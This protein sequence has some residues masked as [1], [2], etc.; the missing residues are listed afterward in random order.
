MSDHGA[1]GYH[2]IIHLD[3]WLFKEGYLKYQHQKRNIS[4]EVFKKVYVQTR[5]YFPRFLKDALK[6]YFPEFR[7][8]IESDLILS[9]IDWQKTKVFSLGIEATHIFIN[10]EGDR[11]SVV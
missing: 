1:G 4:K 10:E 8:K 5:K 6:S 9:N 7:T 11:K 3:R 2:K